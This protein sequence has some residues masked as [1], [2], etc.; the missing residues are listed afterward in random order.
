MLVDLFPRAHARFAALPLLGSHLDIFVRWLGTLG[1][2]KVSISRRVSRTP[3]LDNM[4]RGEGVREL[5][6]LSRA[7]LLAFAPRRSSDDKYLSAVVRSLAA[8]LGERG[9]LAASV[10]TPTEQLVGAYR[11]Y[12]D[13]VRGF[14]AATVRGH[15]ASA[16]GLLGFLHFDDDPTVLRALSAAHLEGFVKSVA[17]RLSRASLQQVAAHLRS[18][19]RFLAS[20]D[21]VA[22][23]LD[24]TIDRP[25]VYRQEQVPRALPWE[26]VQ[27]LLAAIDRTTAMGRRDYAM[28]LI[29][30][31]YGLRASEVT[32]LNLDHITWRAM[33]FHVSRPKTQT[34]I[35]LP[36]TLE[37]GAALLDYLRHGRPPSTHREVF[38]RVRKPCGPLVPSSVGMA[39][40]GWRRRSAR[41]IPAA[42]AHCLRHSLAL[43]LLRQGTSLKAIGDLLGHRSME[44]TCV[45]LRL[46]V[47]D[48]RAA[49]LDLPVETEAHR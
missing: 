47:D 45:Y 37:V 9:T 6:Q 17:A 10:T 29:M 33:Q 31:T 2:A 19:L 32:A 43:H 25:L 21:E 22:T 4:L 27:A 49:A 41:D 18:F 11:D 1:L 34:A 8:Y 14:A 16:S 28:L 7:D 3:R 13:H 46:H 30:A 26:T 44:S 15:D 39:F 35:V 38:L 42:G 5:S 40:D 12:L 23:G 36:L 48:L 20:R 24:A